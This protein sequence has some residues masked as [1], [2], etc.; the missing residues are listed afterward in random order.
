MLYESKKEEDRAILIK[1]RNGICYKIFT[2]SLRGLPIRVL[3][4]HDQAM[5]LSDKRGVFLSN[6]PIDI[7]ICDNI[8]IENGSISIL[9]LRFEEKEKQKKHVEIGCYSVDLDEVDSSVSFTTGQ[10]VINEVESIT[11][12]SGYFIGMLNSGIVSIDNESMKQYGLTPR[13]ILYRNN[14][15]NPKKYIK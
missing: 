14:P 1:Q 5:A 3:M 10:V 13:F 4:R 9:G 2:T 6:N 11:A 15:K 8:T 7:S 12:D